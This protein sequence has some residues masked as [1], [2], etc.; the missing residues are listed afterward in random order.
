MRKKWV[1]TAIIALASGSTVLLSQANSA[2]A[3]TENPTVS[4]VK[5]SVVENENDS[6]NSNNTNQ[7]T[8]QED[9]QAENS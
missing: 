4:N 7:E 9:T 5:V 1:A 8:N 6:Q 3:A 2:Q